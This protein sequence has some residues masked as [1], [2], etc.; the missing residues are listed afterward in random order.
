MSK[1]KT[2]RIIDLQQGGVNAGDVDAFTDSV[3]LRRV[4]QY[5]A[6]SGLFIVSQAL[7]RNTA[8][9]SV[10][11]T[12]EW[13]PPSEVPYEYFSIELSTVSGFIPSESYTANTN[14]AS[15]I[16][17]TNRTYYARVAAV[18][19]TVVSQYSNVVT[20]TTMQDTTVPAN[21]STL[22]LT[23]SR[24]DLEI[25]IPPQDTELVKTTRIRVYNA[26]GTTLYKE[27][28]AVASTRFTAEENQRVAGIPQ[29]SLQI[30][31]Q[32]QSWNNV[33]SAGNY[34]VTTH[35][36]AP[37][38]IIGLTT[39][40]NGDTGTA[41]ADFIATWTRQND[42]TAYVVDL[43]GQ[44]YT[45]TDNTFLYTWSENSRITPPSG[46]FVLPVNVYAIN[47][48]RQSGVLATVTHTNAA[49]PTTGASVSVVA[50]FSQII[51][52]LQ[53]PQINDVYEYRYQLV[54]ASGISTVV[55][56]P[57]KEVTFSAQYTGNHT[58]R[59]NIIDRFGRMS[60]DINSSAVFIEPLTI[61]GLRSAT[62]YT[63]SQATANLAGLKDGDLATVVV[64]HNNTGS[65]R[66]TQAERPLL[67]RVQTMTFA[68]SGLATQVYF[69]VSDGV[70][71]RW[72][73]APLSNGRILTEYANETLASNNRLTYSGITRYDL[74]QMVESRI[75][76]AYHRIPSGTYGLTEFYPRRL[77]QSDDIE[78]ESIRA[79][80][81]AA[82]T[83][84][85]D[86]INVMNLAALAISTGNIVISG[87][88][89]I[90]PNGGIYQG[91]GTFASPTTGLKIFNSSGVG[92][93]ST[94][95]NSIEQISLNTAG[96]FRAGQNSIIL[97][98][99]GVNVISSSLSEWAYGG[100][101]FIRA[102]GQNY[103]IIHGSAGNFGAGL[104][105]GVWDSTLQAHRAYADFSFDSSGTGLPTGN[106]RVLLSNSA[107]SILIRDA[108]IDLSAPTL[109]ISGNTAI[110]T[111]LAPTATLDV[112]RGSLTGGTAV[113]RGTT[114]NSHFNYSSD[115]NT[116]IRGGKA[117]S[118]VHIA[119]VNARVRIGASTGGSTMLYVNGSIQ[120]DNAGADLPAGTGGTAI[121]AGG[122][123]SPT[124]G[125]IVFGDASGWFFRFSTRTGSTT[126]DVVS[127]RD[128]G[129]TGFGISSPA[130]RVELPN[131]ADASGQGR[132]NAWV[133]Y[134]SATRK[135][136]IQ[137]ISL[138]QIMQVLPQL[139]PK[140]FKWE[141]SNVEDF[142]IIAEEIKDIIP[143]LVTGD[144]PETY[145]IKYDRIAV[146]LIPVIKYLY[147]EVQVL[148]QSMNK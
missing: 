32:N 103:G 118:I 147:Q 83:I 41:S 70:T 47:K 84:T 133:T 109:N 71:N 104:R 17:P 138:T 121:L 49:P 76:R 93:L 101:K 14:T 131:V 13:N 132:A 40:W 141:G 38:G 46:L 30:H 35:S 142:G 62:T 127:V 43:A 79:I 26:A 89:S 128:N 23:W 94:F 125:R 95:R 25:T 18:T 107:Q 1:Y 86:K 44:T 58:V 117:A 108:N 34:T 12:L 60:G 135:T 88:A 140:R 116:Y 90:H 53:H 73:A 134:S 45:T 27:V 102:S 98:A 22:T 100:I 106:Y 72:Y 111:S 148:K 31:A 99:S 28:F 145:A 96:E 50:G 144:T 122:F 57:A 5:P 10:I 68:A 123:S 20:F 29:T 77:V 48:L 82:S 61:S 136:N 2:V 75:F 56:T 54:P 67:D 81:I 63:D 97:S 59:A 11:V 66:W 6:P 80:N 36:P 129:Y 91:T 119:D 51:A 52:T 113:F 115:E 7:Y 74:P 143:Q 146:L 114:H 65:A 42:A 110:A 24:G 33:Y 64:T 39:N 120:P 124:A 87:V 92:T 85:A 105:I 16:L 137:N 69:S 139:M 9:P 21:I 3:P 130:Y 15:L 126:T 8:A 78:A 37:S 4:D 112:A 55:R 19:K